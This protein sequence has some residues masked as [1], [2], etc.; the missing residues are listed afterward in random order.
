MPM[1]GAAAGSSRVQRARTARGKSSFSSRDT[2][3]NWA[4]TTARSSRVVRARMIGG[5]MIGTRAM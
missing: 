4:M 3:R 5:W 1:R 2:G